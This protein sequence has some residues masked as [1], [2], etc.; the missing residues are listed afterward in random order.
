VNSRKASVVSQKSTFFPQHI[1]LS[2]VELGNF[3]VKRVV[4][5]LQTQF[6]TVETFCTLSP[7]PGFRSWL[8]TLFS[9]SNTA[10]SELLPQE[11][12]SLQFLQI[13]DG[14][15]HQKSKDAVDI[16]KDILKNDSWI[17]SN[18]NYTDILKPILL[19]LCSRYLIL[20]K[21][22]G[23]ALNQVGNVTRNFYF[24]FFLFYSF[25]CF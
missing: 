2:G 9:N 20:E 4:Q 14:V 13:N 22:R 10:S 5:E 12:Q 16:L 8:E 1:G 21:R 17:T 19:R 23:V 7:I 3:L 18:P 25:C 11:I 15:V 6:P 24:Y